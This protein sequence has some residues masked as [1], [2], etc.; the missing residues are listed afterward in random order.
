MI[1]YFV[2]ACLPQHDPM[3]TDGKIQQARIQQKNTRPSYTIRIRDY[4]L[5][6]L[7]DLLACD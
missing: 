7:V 1:F 4:C 5:F 3:I 2:R 6:V